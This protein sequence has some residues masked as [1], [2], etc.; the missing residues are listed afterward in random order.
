MLSKI[1]Y[2]LVKNAYLIFF[3]IFNRLTVLNRER[4]PKKRPL[5]LASNH[6]S[7]LDPPVVGS[8]FEERMRYIAKASLFQPALFGFALRALGAVP[9]SR[10]DERKAALVLKTFLGFLESGQNVLIFPEG[11]RSEDGTLQP[12]EGGVALLSQKSGCP[13]QPVHVSG[14]FAALPTGSIFPRP[15]KIVMNYGYPIDPEEMPAALSEKA[16]RAWILERLSS[17]YRR[18]ENESAAYRNGRI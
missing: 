18:L 10:E 16:G 1:F 15:V 2:F 3:R 6:C 12:L 7:N 4:I 13:I 17:E 5:I 11:K 8:V 9:V 14:T